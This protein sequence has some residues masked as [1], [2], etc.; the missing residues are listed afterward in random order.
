M[1][2]LKLSD[3]TSMEGMTSSHATTTNS[4]TAQGRRIIYTNESK[5]AYIDPNTVNGQERATTTDEVDLG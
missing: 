2:T 4:G 3:T 1:V 5:D